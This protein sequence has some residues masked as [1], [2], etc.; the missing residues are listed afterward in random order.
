MRQREILR[1]THREDETF[2]AAVRRDERAAGRAERERIARGRQRRTRD[3]HL[4]AEGREPRD[5]GRD[6]VG[7]VAVDGEEDEE[8]AGGERKRNL[9]SL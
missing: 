8:L 2:L 9:L 6:R 5:G 3:P 4:A 7:A 1:E